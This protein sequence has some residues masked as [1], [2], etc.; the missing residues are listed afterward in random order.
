MA[1]VAA[2]VAVVVR[3]TGAMM[4]RMTMIMLSFFMPCENSFTAG[5]LGGAIL[6]TRVSE[7]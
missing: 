3:M 6:N 1:V 2:A 4:V 5:G 7:G